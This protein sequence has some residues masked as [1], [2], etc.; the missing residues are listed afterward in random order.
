VWK[1]EQKSKTVHAGF[2]KTLKKNVLDS[3]AHTYAQPGTY[4]ARLKV[5][6]E[7]GNSRTA[8]LSIRVGNAPPT[9]R[10]DLAGKN[11][12]FY[13]PGDT[14]HYSVA[15][16]DLEDG[17]LLSGSIAPATVATTIDYLATGF[18]ITSIA[19]GHQAA[20]KTAEYS[21]GKLLTDRSDCKTC[22]ALD[23]K[24][25]GP[26]YQD[27]ATRYRDNA[28][29]VRNLTKK[30]IQGGA[31]NWGQVV[32]SAHPQLSDS[33]VGEMVRWILSLGD[34]PRPKQ[35]LPP[36]GTYALSIPPPEK[37]KQ[38]APG[39]FILKASYRDR[40]STA[41]TWLESGEVLALRPAFLQ[42]EQADSLSQGIRTYRPF[43]GDT[44]VL[45]DM[46]SG[47]FLLF[48]HTD[49]TGI[50]NV[51]VG[52]GSG[53]KNTRT[54]GGVLEIR[55]DSPTGPLLGSAKVAAN[56]PPKRMEFS[57]LDVPLTTRISDGRFH[58]VYLV[59]KNPGSGTA[60]VVALDWVRFDGKW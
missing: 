25:N 49:L 17:S 11:R 14:L 1:A 27:I 39:T 53:D 23:Y 60:P 22:H 10:W 21:R 18:D 38:P 19:Q 9:V 30:I 46:K 45:R 34:A 41:Q 4:T 15:V 51:A 44:V 13:Q 8:K 36:I 33:D 5:T 6:D 54:S 35:A 2:S 59:V 28:F 16:S 47:S 3:I 7:A 32:M 42:A 12:S 48:K 20:M 52:I 40:G 26:A 57:V 24:V 31:G 37:G 56:N 58:D 55:L 43:D 50:H 29:A